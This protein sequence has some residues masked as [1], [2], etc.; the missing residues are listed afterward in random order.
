[1]TKVPVEREMLAAVL[2]PDAH[3][4]EDVEEA[5]LA[6]E[7]VVLAEPQQA[8][9]VAWHSDEREKEMREAAEFMRMLKDDESLPSNIRASGAM[10]EARFERLTGDEFVPVDYLLERERLLHR[11]LKA[12][13]PADAPTECKC[14]D[15]QQRTAVTQAM[16]HTNDHIHEAA[17][18]VKLLFIQAHF[19]TT[20]EIA[21]II[22]TTLREAVPAKKLAN[23]PV[24]QVNCDER[25][26][27]ACLKAMGVSRE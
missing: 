11:A 27:N 2:F 16:T 9:P 21:A 5:A 13:P 18:A 20:E 26:W 23:L 14:G 22:R 24:E 7:A 6:L 17:E 1:M 12:H 10:L 8:E 19:P 25:G 4:P 15:R 3:E